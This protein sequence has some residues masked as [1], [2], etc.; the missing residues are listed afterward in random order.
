MLGNKPSLDTFKKLGFA[1]Y[2]LQTQCSKIR[3]Q[4]KENL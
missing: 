2:V 1:K 4:Q 3:N